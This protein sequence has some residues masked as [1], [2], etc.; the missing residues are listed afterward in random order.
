MYNL[1]LIVWSIKFVEVYF[2][3]FNLMMKAYKFIHFLRKSVLFRILN[4]IY[5]LIV[6]EELNE[7]LKTKNTNY[8]MISLENPKKSLLVNLQNVAAFF[9]LV[10]VRL[11]LMHR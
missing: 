6:E 5:I 4:Q 8:V 1:Q 2:N 11:F 10:N 9:L 7:I 3:D